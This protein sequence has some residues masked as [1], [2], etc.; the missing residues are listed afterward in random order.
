VKQW[1]AG[2]LVENEF[3]PADEPYASSVVSGTQIAVNTSDPVKM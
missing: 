1:C 3:V 2:A